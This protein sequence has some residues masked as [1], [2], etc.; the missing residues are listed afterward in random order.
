MSVIATPP[1]TLGQSTEPILPTPAIPTNVPG[2]FGPDYNFSDN[3]PFP[4]EVGVYDGD[5]VG[6][7]M[8]AGRAAAYYIDV[9]GFG[10][11]TNKFSKAAEGKIGKPL[12][13]IGV[14]TFIDSGEVCS[15]GAKMWDYIQGIPTGNSVGSTLSGRIQSSG[16]PP[17]RGLAPGILEDIETALDPKPIV[18]AV[19]GTGYPVCTY[20]VLPVGDQN[21]S[22]VNTS[23]GK[24]FVADASAVSGSGKAASE[25][26]WIKSGETTRE[27]YNNTP[28]THCLDGYP[29]TNHR[30]G[31]CLKELLTKNVSG[32]EDLKESREMNLLKMIGAVTGVLFII[33]AGHAA[34]KLKK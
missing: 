9:V 1:L 32:F 26:H 30:D 28:K 15:N 16:F 24:P 21:G 10:T 2:I 33:A 11:S 18:T 8:D 5:S 17:M 6:S 31:D 3:V 13:P 14:N 29:K 12:Q 22:I 7:V 25:G 34:F 4:S 27:L 19:F 20:S 23:T